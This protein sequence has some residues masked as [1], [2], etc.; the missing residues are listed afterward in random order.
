MSNDIAKQGQDALE[1]VNERRVV[2][3][4]VDIYENQDEFLVTADLPAVS[5]DALGI[6][7]DAERLTREGR[8]SALPGHRPD[9][10]PELVYRRSFELPDT[11]DRDKVS[12]VLDKGVL[13]LHLPKLEAV[14]PRRIT[15]RAA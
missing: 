11:I 14:K 9:E 6:R 8:V 4:P 1:Q 3:P 5:K 7:L 13:T 15:V 12:A 10:A 2:R